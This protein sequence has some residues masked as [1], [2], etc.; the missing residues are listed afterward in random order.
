[1][2]RVVE[3]RGEEKG[4][5]GAGRGQTIFPTIFFLKGIWA[6]LLLLPY[7]RFFFFSRFLSHQKFAYNCSLSN[8]QPLCFH[9][10]FRTLSNQNLCLFKTDF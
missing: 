6:Q 4:K 2:L 10:G 3:K 7:L 5:E 9:F 8:Q 1:M